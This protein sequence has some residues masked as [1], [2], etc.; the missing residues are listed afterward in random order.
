MI[1]LDDSVFD[2]SDEEN[3]IHDL[4]QLNAA[5]DSQDPCSNATGLESL[6]GGSIC[7]ASSTYGEY[8]KI[9]T[10][11]ALNKM[12]EEKMRRLEGILHVRLIECRKRL[13]QVQSTAFSN[14]IYYKENFRYVQCG[15]PYFKDSCGFPA[16]DNEDTLL[17]AK[18]NMYNCSGIA[19][20]PGWTFKD[21]SSLNNII[22]KMSKEIR[23]KELTKQISNLTRE[24]KLS[25][26]TK[27]KKAISE[28]RN[29]IGK[30]DKMSLK[31]LALPINE[32][33]DWDYI[34]SHMSDRHS[35]QEYRSLWK[36]FLHPS[37]NKSIWSKSEH[38]AIQRIAFQH[39]LQD[40]DAISK[41]LNSGRTN[42]QSFVYFRTNMNNTVIGGKW[43]REEEEYLK[44]LIEY[45]KED[46]Y[47]PWGKVAA[48]MENRTKVQIYNKFY[49]L[50]ELR[51]GKFLQE[52]DSV[53]LSCVQHFGPNFRKVT[54]YLQ[55]RSVTQCRDRYNT[56]MRHN[57]SAVWTVE[58]DRKLV[59]LVSTQD[60]A[61]VFSTIT[62]FFPGKDRMNIRT[63]Y[64]TLAKWIKRHPNTNIAHA[65]RR[66][67]RRLGHGKSTKD[68]SK[69]I[70]CLK[71]R[72]QSEVTDKKKRK[73]TVDSP[74][75]VIDDAMVAVLTTELTIQMAAE[76]QNLL[77]QEERDDGRCQVVIKDYE[78]THL[79]RILLLLKS[80]LNKHK[81][82]NSPS[83]N[84]HQGLLDVKFEKNYSQF[85]SYSKTIAVKKLKS[86]KKLDI[87]GNG[88]LENLAYVLPPQYA[89]IIGCKKVTLS[90]Q[91]PKAQHEEPRNI[92][93]LAKRNL[94]VRNELQLLI[95]RFHTIFLWPILL[96]S[97]TPNVYKTYITPPGAQNLNRIMR[98]SDYET[99]SFT[100]DYN[101]VL[102]KPD[103]KTV[104]SVKKN[105]NTIDLVESN[106]SQKIN[107]DENFFESIS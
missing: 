30:V 35:A 80:K 76:R 58:E 27:N 32:E 53:I 94:M 59:Q 48:S 54:E 100:D 39:H 15:K 91:Y 66:G 45:Y 65:P 43:T 41:E 14:N 28:L 8:S 104:K 71:K 82:A 38:T 90:H 60:E 101:F 16:P 69:A 107:I 99:R 21:K 77:L 105:Q 31:K 86:Q 23:K 67:A 7:S 40:W 11:L 56:L 89:T 47:I 24:N 63:R 75:N 46:N 5:L 34:A 97:S 68:L 42:Y 25:K 96:S 61:T 51:K 93:I 13:A 26:S 62:R 44:R 2:S 102:P 57:F 17:M 88:T 10:A 20:V 95:E 70:E 22:T 33:Y 64:L 1:D 52:E 83:R 85:R 103:L 36:L 106:D 74:E 49:R 92:N 81:F 73:V 72:L 55:G 79:H 12:C 19:S 87:W 98:T 84:T 9:E 50:C 4:E 29:E 18:S 6:P 37:I 78:V 3:D